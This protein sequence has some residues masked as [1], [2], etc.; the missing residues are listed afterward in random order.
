MLGTFGA[1]ARQSSCSPADLSSSVDTALV[2]AAKKRR[3]HDATIMYVDLTHGLAATEDPWIPP[4][5]QDDDHDDEPNHGSSAAQGANARAV[6][7]SS[8]ARN[9]GYAAQAASGRSDALASRGAALRDGVARFTRMLSHAPPP[10][11]GSAAWRRWR[12]RQRRQ[13]AEHMGSGGGEAAAAGGRRGSAQRAPS[14]HVDLNRSSH[15]MR[16]SGDSCEGDGGEGVLKSMAPEQ[17]EAGA[18][19]PFAHEHVFNCLETLC[20]L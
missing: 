18:L 10:P 6:A 2:Y 20:V 16:G 8:S 7:T 15:G 11:R 9:G 19:L 5:P 3:K 17:K 13:R 1:Q 14:V 12:R 4:A